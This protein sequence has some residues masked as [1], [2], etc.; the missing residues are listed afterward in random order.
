MS[1]R[2]TILIRE[3]DDER[4]LVDA[5]AFRRDACSDVTVLFVDP[6]SVSQ[7]DPPFEGSGQA[8]VTRLQSQGSDQATADTPAESERVGGSMSTQARARRSVAAGL[9]A[10]LIL[11]LGLA[12]YQQWRVA[13]ALRYALAETRAQASVPWLPDSTAPAGRQT[14]TVDVGIR[15]YA[16][17]RDVDIHQRETLEDRGA[18]LLGSNSFPA[19]LAHYQMLTEVFPEETAFRDVVTVLRSKLRCSDSDDPSSSACP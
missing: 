19:A 18:S 10:A 2:P 12:V 6:G 4:T 11:G 13:R 3:P 8:R 1:S 14:A 15:P 5:R 16:M 9:V 7:A 17:P